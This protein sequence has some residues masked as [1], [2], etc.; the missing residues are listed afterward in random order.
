MPCGRTE[1][2]KRAKKGRE[3]GWAEPRAAALRNLVQANR[4]LWCKAHPLEESCVR[5]NWPL[6]FPQHWGTGWGGPGKARPQYKLC[7]VPGVQ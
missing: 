3:V 2:G 6:M 5:Q 7:F 4:K 1:S